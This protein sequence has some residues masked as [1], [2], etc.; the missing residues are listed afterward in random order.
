MRRYMSGHHLNGKSS[1]TAPLGG[2]NMRLVMPAPCTPTNRPALATSLTCVS[3]GVV[4][5]Q[6]SLI[7]QVVWFWHTAR[8]SVSGNHTQRREW[9]IK[10]T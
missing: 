6:G 2:R 3:K 4:W 9:A 10:L 8:S 7:T 1:I 5:S